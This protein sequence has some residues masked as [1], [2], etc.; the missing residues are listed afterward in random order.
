MKDLIQ[1]GRKIQETFKKNIVETQNLNEGVLYNIWKKVMDTIERSGLQIIAVATAAIAIFFSPIALPIGIILM[2][3]AT[4]SGDFRVTAEEFFA[5][6]YFDKKIMP[7]IQELI[8]ELASN[9]E[10][11]NLISKFSKMKSSG[12]SKEIS[13][14]EYKEMSNTISEVLSSSLDK[15]LNS[16]KFKDRLDSLIPDRDSAGGK[17]NTQF[18]LADDKIKWIKQYIIDNIK[19]TPSEYTT[20]KSDAKEMKESL[21]R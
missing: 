10:I 16:P 19:A 7:V 15:I 3:V 1:E 20:I 18:N 5:K 11:K 2:E 9:S 8:K 21:K 14:S 12:N 4:K 13:S 17:S 6:R